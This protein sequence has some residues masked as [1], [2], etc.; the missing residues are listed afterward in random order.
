MYQHTPTS[1]FCAP[2]TFH[3]ESYGERQAVD[4]HGHQAGCSGEQQD[5]PIDAKEKV[6]GAVLP[7]H[8]LH[9]ALLLSAVEM[10]VRSVGHELL[11][12]DT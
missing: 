4:G 9:P 12:H 7:V 1:S 8:Q 2:L 6:H 10:R 11:H 5:H 3:K